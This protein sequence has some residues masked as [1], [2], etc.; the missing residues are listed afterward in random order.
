MRVLR[1]YF[2]V[3]LLAVI[4]FSI[5]PKEFIHDLYDHSDTIENEYCLKGILHVES[6][7]H[8]CEMLNYAA[9]PFDGVAGEIL[10]NDLPHVALQM[11]QV[12]YGFVKLDR[13]NLSRFRAPPKA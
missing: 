3:I 10:F 13:F 8:H 12:D 5:T 9:F 6:I 7:H 11:S 1:T 2:S 4:S